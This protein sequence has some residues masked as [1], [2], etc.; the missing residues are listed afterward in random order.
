MTKEKAA[1][2]TDQ[3][4]AEIM[5]RLNGPS[6]PRI[7]AVA[8]RYEKR[9][10]PG[11]YT[12]SPKT[13]LGIEMRANQTR[14]ASLFLRACKDFLV[15]D[16][17]D[18]ALDYRTDAETLEAALQVIRRD[19]RRYFDSLLADEI[20]VDAP[21]DENGRKVGPVRIISRRGDA[22]VA[23]L[24]KM[25]KRFR[26]IADDYDKDP[27]NIT[28]FYD[29]GRIFGLD[30]LPSAG[31][32]NVVFVVLIETLRSI[33]PQRLIRIRK[34]EYDSTNDGKQIRDLMKSGASASL[35]RAE[36]N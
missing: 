13:N 15:R 18:R 6:F 22:A 24:D 29:V 21:A 35:A 2:I 26:E 34:A 36:A 5:V 23:A 14:V 11:R 20:I 28:F 27:K 17:I 33:A 1:E 25:A 19:D 7:Y 8:E 31:E 32:A 3:E 4:L 30:G 16:S 10:F 12:P 9:K